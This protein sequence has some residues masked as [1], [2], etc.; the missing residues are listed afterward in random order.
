LFLLLVSFDVMPHTP[1][2]VGWR[3]GSLLTRV[4]LEEG[5]YALFAPNPDSINDR[6]RIEITY[7]D[8][9]RAQWVS[10]DWHRQTLWERWTG[11]RRWQWLDAML[12][13]PDSA[14]EPWCRRLARLLRPDLDNA[15]SG[16]DVRV[17]SDQARIPPAS[18]QPWTSWRQEIPYS[19]V[20]VLAHKSL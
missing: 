17:I 12:G 15:D 19:A 7:R 6:I 2:A 5:V 9:R 16:A 4:G 11:S 3:V 20:V 14:F 13:K 8:G 10:P 18:K 1:R